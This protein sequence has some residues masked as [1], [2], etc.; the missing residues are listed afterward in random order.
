[1][2]KFEDPLNTAVFTTKFV[3]TDRKLITYVANE[4]E[5]GDWQFFSD[6]KFDN[7]EDV[8]MLVGLGEIIDFDNSVLEIANLPL[9]YKATRRKATD[10]W[11]QKK[12]HK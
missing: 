12:A 6:D 10:K 9:G 11:I 8:A 5:D 1:M 2:N 7:Y 3:V 4:L